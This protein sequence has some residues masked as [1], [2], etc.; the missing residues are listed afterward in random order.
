MIKVF[1]S[2]FGDDRSWEL[3]ILQTPKPLTVAAQYARFSDA[4]V[5]VARGHSALPPS[6]SVNAMNFSYRNTCG[7]R[8]RLFFKS[9]HG[10][11]RSHSPGG[12]YQQNQNFKLR[13]SLRTPFLFCYEILQLLWKICQ[14]S[15]LRRNSVFRLQS[16]GTHGARLPC[17]STATTAIR[18]TAAPW[19]STAPRR[20]R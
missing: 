6:T 18:W 16:D 7:L 5:R 10:K 20:C 17:P 1:P 9:F 19:T 4:A 13:A 3:V 12:Y 15:W 11:G 14:T 2:G 8:G